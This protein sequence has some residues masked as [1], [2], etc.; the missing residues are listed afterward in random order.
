MFQRSKNAYKI[1][2]NGDG[3]G[4][5]VSKR[6]V[7]RIVLR[8]IIGLVMVGSI[9]AGGYYYYKYQE[10]SKDPQSVSTAEIKSITGDVSKLIALPK[11]EQPTIATVQDKEKLKD[12]PF[13]KD[14]QNGD[15]VLIYTTS[16]KAIVYRPTTHTLVNV[17]PIAIN[18]TATTD[19]K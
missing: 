17:G 2:D 15:K 13:F 19:K 10:I 16:K 3:V 12:Q 14:S 9:S 7:K 5:N 8:A 4:N 18:D 6:N 1:R 11:D